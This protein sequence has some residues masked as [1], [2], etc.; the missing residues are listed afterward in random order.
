M[1]FMW[2]ESFS[3]VS[4]LVHGNE[5]VGE[6]RIRM[7]PKPI[8]RPGQLLVSCGLQVVTGKSGNGPIGKISRLQY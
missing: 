4:Y 1:G 2:A 6:D 7:G 5:Y 8:E 3:V